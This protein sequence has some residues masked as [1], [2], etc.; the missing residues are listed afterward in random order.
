VLSENNKTETKRR[1]D[2]H[3]EKIE[4]LTECVEAL[5]TEP[6]AYRRP[7]LNPKIP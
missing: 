6:L 1:L 3:S 7:P 4:Q 5:F 2:E